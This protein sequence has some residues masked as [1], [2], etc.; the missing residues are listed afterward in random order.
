VQDVTHAKRERERE[1]G[2]EREKAPKKK[3]HCKVTRPRSIRLRILV[4]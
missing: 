2:R 1:R 3:E 4:A